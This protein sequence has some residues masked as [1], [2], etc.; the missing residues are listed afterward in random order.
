MPGQSVT[1]PTICV[2]C[3]MAC[4]V[5][6][7]LREQRA[8]TVGAPKTFSLLF[9]G[10]SAPNQVLLGGFGAG[11]S[12]LFESSPGPLDAFAPAD[13]QR[14]DVTITFQAPSTPGAVEGA[15]E[16]ESEATLDGTTF[17]GLSLV[18]LYARVVE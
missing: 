1:L 17:N 12:E 16:Y 10:D 6:M 7:K 11:P 14:I 9:Q 4:L 15:L 3:D 13:C 8:G 18:P 2:A 5:L